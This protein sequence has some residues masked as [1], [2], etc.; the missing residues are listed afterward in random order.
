MVSLKWRRRWKNRPVV[1][2]ETVVGLMAEMVGRSSKTR[3]GEGVGCGNV[4]N[5]GG[6]QGCENPVGWFW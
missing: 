3:L 5:L 6:V 2:E 1:Q 4:G